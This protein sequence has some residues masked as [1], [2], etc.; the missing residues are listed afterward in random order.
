MVETVKLVKS[1][2]T[3]EQAEIIAGW[4]RGLRLGQRTLADW[5]GGKLAVSAVPG[6]GK[7]HSMA[8][9]AAITIARE[10]LHS[11]RQ[12]VIVTL[13]RTAAANIQDKIRTCLKE[14]GLPPIGYSVSTIHSLALNIASKHPELSKLD[15]VDRTLVTP[16]PNH[17]VIKKTVEQWLETRPDSYQRLLAEKSFEGEATER[18]RRQSVLRT[19]ILPNLAYTVVKEAK[20]SDLSPDQ[21]ADLA[22][23]YPD[24]YDI[25]EVGAGLY[26]AYQGVMKAENYVDYDEMILGALRVLQDPDACKLWQ[27]QVFAVFEDEAQDSSPLQEQLLR[28]LAGIPNR[29]DL[30]PNLIRVGDPN[31]AINS[32]F[33]PADPKYFREFCQECNS[34]NLLER[35]DQAGRSTQVIMDGANYVLEWG[36]NLLKPSSNSDR[37]CDQPESVFWLQNILGVSDGDAQPNPQP[38]GGGIEL[39]TPLD[40]YESVRSIGERLIALFG[41]NPLANAAILVRENR[42]AKYVLDRLTNQFKHIEPQI[43]IF[44]AGE[45]DRT[46]KIPQEILTIFQFLIRPHSPEHLKSTLKVLLARKLIDAQDLDAL[47]IFPEQFL[48]PSILDI[49]RTPTVERA[50]RI[51]CELLEARSSLPHYHLISYISDRLG[52]LSSE[53]ATADKLA[54]RIS[55]E[56]YNRGSIYS[57]IEVLQEIVTEGFENISDDSES[58]YTASGQVTIITMHKAKGLDWDYVFIPFLSDKIPGKLWTPQ[59]AKFLGEFT[60]S[61]VARA[62][63][64]AHLHHQAIPTPSEAWAMADYLKQG[65]DLRL[66]YVAMT[67]AKKLLWL[68]AEKKGPFLWNRFNGQEGDGLREIKQSSLFIALSKKFPSFKILKD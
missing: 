49:A 34:D 12:L 54:H 1:S 42:Q 50:S 10:K 47:A 61:E 65:E 23:R 5:C 57:S 4:R 66:L 62:K 36:N 9:A 60:L 6:A 58:Q 7:S 28:K 20:S 59:G 44:E 21:L 68:A 38:E 48:Y 55:I 11:R 63:I 37:D 2:F 27:Q 53:L 14:L 29:E 52:Y 45:G 64:R 43:K 25:L 33:T 13:T 40:V 35:M 15:L 8:V 30:P 16:S 19:E 22:R 32:T 51:C 39:H 46:S 3:S 56:T 17:Q 67:R 31:Q 18:L 41:R 24:E 26:Q